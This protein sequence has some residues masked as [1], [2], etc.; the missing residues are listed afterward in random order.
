M[1]GG[2]TIAIVFAMAFGVLADGRSQDEVPDARPNGPVPEFAAPL[3]AEQ[4]EAGNQFLDVLGWMFWSLSDGILIVE[5]PMEFTEDDLN[6]LDEM[7][8]ATFEEYQPRIKSQLL[9]LKK[10]GNLSDEQFEAIR[11]CSQFE[12]KSVCRKHFL[13][14][15]QS[16]MA[17]VAE[18]ITDSDSGGTESLPLVIQRFF[19][20]F[21][22]SQIGFD[23]MKSYETELAARNAHRKR[24]TILNLVARLDADLLLMPDQREQFTKLIDSEWKDE[25]AQSMSAL[26]PDANFMP[27]L[28]DGKVLAIL[29]DDQREVWKTR[30]YSRDSVEWE[31]DP[32]DWLSDDEDAENAEP[33][34]KQRD[35]GEMA[36]PVAIRD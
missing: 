31:S 36:K 29:K 1:F 7:I 18:N 19:V 25:W 24:V 26:M 15:R 17:E 33:D 11:D 13:K 21:V 32:I 4:F 34:E 5:E 20:D 30:Q 2:R 8:E 10:T 28:P 16:A 3:T 9:F 27:A 6:E 35:N 23:Q 22:R 12:L 14:A